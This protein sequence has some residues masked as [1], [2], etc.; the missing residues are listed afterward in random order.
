MNKGYWCSIAVLLYCVDFILVVKLLLNFSK[1]A[2]VIIKNGTPWLVENFIL[3]HCNHCQVI[4][5]MTAFSF[6]NGSQIC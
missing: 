3:S 4:I 2:L 5:A 6:Q 1:I